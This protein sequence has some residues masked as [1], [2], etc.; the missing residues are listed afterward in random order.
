[1]LEP[2]LDQI[3]KYGPDIVSTVLIAFVGLTLSVF[4]KRVVRT[5]VQRSGLEGA[6]ESAGIA[7]MLYLVGARDGL[8]AFLGRCTMWGGLLGTAAVLCDRFGLSLVRTVLSA[9]LGYAPRLIVALAIAF[10]TI[11]LSS[12]VQRAVERT[13]TTRSDMRSPG[14][15][16]GAARGLVIMVGITLAAGQ[17]GLEVGFITAIFEIVVGVACLALGLA[18]ALGFHGIVRGMA[19]RHYYRPLV[20]PGDRVTIGEDHGTVVKFGSTAIVL[21]DQDKER[22]VPCERMLQGTVVISAARDGEPR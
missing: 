13:L 2:I 21:R 19:A 14:P 6:A 12:V 5:L 20:R 3:R 10:G 18:F 4:A 15:I 16:A 8:A 22:I 11:V 9:V 17:A 1:M 7:P